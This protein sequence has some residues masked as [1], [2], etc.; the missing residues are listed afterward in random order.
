MAKHWCICK[1]C[2]SVSDWNSTCYSFRLHS[3]Y[4]RKRHLDWHLEW[5]NNTINLSFAN[6]FLHK[7]GKTGHIFLILQF[8]RF[9]LPIKK[10]QTL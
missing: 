10:Y 8:S 9:N 5:G 7:L 3:A 1:P 4:E 2:G 6:H